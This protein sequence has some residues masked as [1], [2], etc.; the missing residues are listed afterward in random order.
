MIVAIE[1]PS[2]AGKTTWC[3]EHYPNVTVH[4]THD[5]AAPDLFADPAEVGRFWI[6]HNV[7]RWQ[8][9]LAIEQVRG[10]AICDGDPFHLYFSWA[11]WKA[12][13]LPGTLFEL[14]SKLYRDEFEKQQIGFADYIIWLEVPVDE[15]RRRAESDTVRRRKRHEM[16]LA[17]SPW[18]RTWFHAREA[19][20]PGSVLCSTDDLP[21]ELFP[22]VSPSRRYDIALFDNAL[23][24]LSDV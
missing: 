17:M 21:V 13:A 6:A 16:Y 7:A 2:A 11:V 18:M 22:P 5:I 4:E 14:E 3:R 12:G 23:L 24:R 19:A 10:I 8:R 15:L 9:A 20:L 1:G